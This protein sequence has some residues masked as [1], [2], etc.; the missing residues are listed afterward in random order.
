MH[1]YFEL[2]LFLDNGC[3]VLGGD[4]LYY[5]SSSGGCESLMNCGCEFAGDGQDVVV[6]I[7]QEGNDLHHQ[8]I[9]SV[10]VVMA[11][12]YTWSKRLQHLKV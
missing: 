2:N 5:L 6:M 11:T 9:L 1:V 3:D 12:Q 4:S 7:N 8:M 10:R